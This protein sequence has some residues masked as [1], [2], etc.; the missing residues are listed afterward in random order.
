MPI[1]VVIAVTKVVHALQSVLLAIHV[2]L[3]IWYAMLTI[4]MLITFL[5]PV[6]PWMALFVPALLIMLSP[7]RLG[8]A[9]RR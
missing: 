7:P 2:L 3:T 9:W 1:R 6:L 4:V 5:Y 8:D